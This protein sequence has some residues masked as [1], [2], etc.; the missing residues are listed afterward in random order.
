MAEGKDRLAAITAALLLLAPADWGCA[1]VA[2]PQPNDRTGPLESPVAQDKDKADPTPT[3]MPTVCF[4]LNNESGEHEI[5][6]ISPTPQIPPN[7]VLKDG[8]NRDVGYAKEARKADRAAG[9]SVQS[10]EESERVPVQ[11]LLES[12]DYT[13]DVEAWL[14]RKRILHVSED[15]GG[16]AIHAAVPILLMPELSRMDGVMEITKLIPVGV[17]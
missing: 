8:L 12:A 16:D 13:E 5:C 6:R 9:R 4:T 11:I 7:N 10:D 2:Q 17:D 1:S 15:L 3:P 14:T